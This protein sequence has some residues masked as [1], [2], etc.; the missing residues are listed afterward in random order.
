[1]GGGKP[2]TGQGD[3]A[4]LCTFFGGEPSETELTP[5]QYAVIDRMLGLS[6]GTYSDDRLIGTMLPAVLKALKEI[7]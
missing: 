7:D 3:W 5:V 2:F 1:M 4:E 6:D